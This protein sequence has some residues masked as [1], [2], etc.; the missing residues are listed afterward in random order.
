[1]HVSHDVIYACIN[2]HNT[3]NLYVHMQTEIQVSRLLSPYKIVIEPRQFNSR[4][5]DLKSVT[6]LFVEE[7]YVRVFMLNMFSTFA[8]IVLCEVS[9]IRIAMLG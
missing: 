1:M 6:D 7:R 9:L 5:D 2:S 8:R 4:I 3:Y